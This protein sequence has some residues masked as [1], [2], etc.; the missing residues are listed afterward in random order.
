[1]VCA[2]LDAATRNLFVIAFNDAQTMI[3]GTPLRTAQS[4]K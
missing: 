3:A 1:M 2:R 4:N